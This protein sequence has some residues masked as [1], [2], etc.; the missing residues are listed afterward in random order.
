MASAGNAKL[1]NG[2]IEFAGA[3][4]PG[5]ISNLGISLSGGTLS[6]V[7]A[8]G[9]TLT[10]ENPGFVTVPSTTA[11]QMVTLKVTVGGSF[12]DDSHA[13][14]H[15]TNFGFGITET[16]AWA[17]DMPF[18]LYVINRG[19]SDIDGADGSSVFC[20]ARNPAMATSPSSG[21][22]IGDQGANPVTDDQTS[23]LIMD[24]V[25]VANYTS[26]PAQITG[27]IRMQWSTVTDDW[28]VQ[29]LGNKDGLG[30]RQLDKL[31]STWF[32]MPLA[33]NG[34]ATG[35]YIKAN[36]GTAPIF[37]TNNYFYKPNLLGDCYL[38]INLSGDG[39]TDGAGAVDTQIALPYSSVETFTAFI[40]PGHG[41]DP[42][43]GQQGIVLQTLST[44]GTSA[45]FQRDTNS[46]NMQNGD[47]T[48]GSRSI[49]ATGF[50]RAF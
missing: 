11:G 40:G 3:N 33:Q 18:F 43:N 50:Y 41:V 31:I 25:T 14:S 26:L 48:N 44:P 10:D 5:W 37:T 1:K 16:A 4:T 19:N 15:L 28:T 6:I 29:T 39:G 34:A 30:H 8:Q 13:S 22:N 49:G 21:N 2:V 7:D 45:V 27:G 46:A 47:F 36:G 24:D 38:A 35:T 20:L 23:I 12:N 9:A 32:T 42:T 17:N